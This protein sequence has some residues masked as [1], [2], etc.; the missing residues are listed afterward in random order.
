MKLESSG[1]G[2][3]V[4]ACECIAKQGFGQLLAFE[5]CLGRTRLLE[6]LKRWQ[7]SW[8]CFFN[9]IIYLI[10]FGLQVGELKTHALHLLGLFSIRALFHQL[11]HFNFKLIIFPPQLC[12]ETVH[13]AGISQVC[14]YWLQS[15]YSFNV[16]FLT[17]CCHCWKGPGTPVMGLFSATSAALE[18]SQNNRLSQWLLTSS[19]WGATFN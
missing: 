10:Y 5:I 7:M 9:G 6:W 11:Y 14:M 19:N 12:W 18:Y 2:A 3:N 17:C 4:R 8:L 13:T 1:T 16:W 15:L